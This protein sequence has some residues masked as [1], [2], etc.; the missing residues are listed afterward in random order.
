MSG[1]LRDERARMAKVRRASPDD[2]AA[3]AAFGV[4]GRAIRYG[5]KGELSQGPGTGLVVDSGVCLLIDGFAERRA[6]PYTEAI[7]VALASGNTA[8]PAP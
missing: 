5:T 1:A 7:D 3:G 4:V 6:R 8:P 2:L